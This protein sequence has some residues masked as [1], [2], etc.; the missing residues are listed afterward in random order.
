MRPRITPEQWPLSPTV[1][2][3][4]EKPLE[5]FSDNTNIESTDKSE[6]KTDNPDNNLKEESKNFENNV[7]TIEETKP[8]E[9][10]KVVKGFISKDI[11]LEE[12]TQ[13]TDKWQQVKNKRQK[14]GRVGDSSNSLTEENKVPSTELDFQFD[15]EI[16]NLKEKD[17]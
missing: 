11:S 5:H 17:R 9:N 4:S 3:S 12:K 10:E 7:K 1:L 15:E 8:K 6:N 13:E 2:G 16:D 14:K